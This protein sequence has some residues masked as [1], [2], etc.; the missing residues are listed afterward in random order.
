[1]WM[2]IVAV[3]T[4]ACAVAANQILSDGSWQWWPWA[5]I[6]VSTALVGVVIANRPTS[7]ARIDSLDLSDCVKEE[8]QTDDA[9]ALP[10][11]GLAYCGTASSIWPLRFGA[12]PPQAECFQDRDLA[13]LLTDRLAQGDTVALARNTPSAQVL[14]GLGGVGKTQLAA[15]HAHRLWANQQLDLLVWITAGS[16]RDIQVA[17]AKL[18]ERVLD[19]K[20]NGHDMPDPGE[21]ARRLLEWL[22]TTPLRWLIVL[23]DLVEPNDLHGLWPPHSPTGQV[24]VTTRRRDA[25]MRGGHRDI[26]DVGL[27]TDSEALA[28]LVARL[29]NRA[30]TT[31]EQDEMARLANDLEWLPLALAQAAA[32]LIN[33]P[34]LTCA[35]YRQRLGDRRTILDGVLPA[36]RELPDE[37]HHTVAA[38]WSLSI[39]RA[40]QLDPVGLARPILELMS[41]LDP[42]G[43]PADLFAT[44]AV[45]S[46]LSDLLGQSI[47]SKQAEDAIGCLYRLSLLSLDTDQCAR[48]IRV[49]AL[50]QR[51]TRESLSTAELAMIASV[52]GEAILTAWPGE[53]YELRTSLRSN[54]SALFCHA[55]T[56]LWT[57]NARRLLL[58]VADDLTDQ[59]LHADTFP[60]L[61]DEAMLH[62]GVDD[63]DTLTIR[64]RLASYYAEA[65]EFDRA[66]SQA[67][68][69]L[70]GHLQLFGADHVD[71]LATS[72]SIA[73]WHMKM[74]RPDKALIELEGLVS[75]QTR[76]AGPDNQLTL[77]TR[78][79]LA[80]ARSES[81][82]PTRAM[83]ELKQ[84]VADQI[85]LFGPGHELSL[86]ARAHLIRVLARAG[87]YI[88]ATAEFEQLI[89]DRM[90]ILGP[91]GRIIPT[92][93][94]SLV[95]H[96]K[97]E[98][99]S[100]RW[101]V[102]C[103]KLMLDVAGIPYGS[104]YELLLGRYEFIHESAAYNTAWAIK[105][106][107]ALLVDALH[108]WG[109]ASPLTLAMRHNLAK[110]L[111]WSGDTVGAIAEW[112]LL[113]IDQLRILGPDHPDTR[114]T[115]ENLIRL[116]GKRIGWRQSHLW[117]RRQ[118]RRLAL[119]QKR[120]RPSGWPSRTPIDEALQNI[121][122]TMP[123]NDS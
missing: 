78:V 92:L 121:R 58:A 116:S 97:F 27:F 106:L 73:R 89:A 83:A 117:L 20:P 3:L 115:Q 17:Y 7:M 51:V 60:E 122:A 4:V 69:L 104:S 46:Y 54:V 72:H 105:N 5:P 10:N 49:H 85:Q 22:A 33:R 62:A 74:G 87:Q 70:A 18:A 91:S 94:S 65:G 9:I 81:G 90:Q 25:A 61:L 26:L 120:K 41:V 108:A 88:I 80:I 28:Y 113:T 110:W 31:Q 86:N 8:P 35:E 37:Q 42:V 43:I 84:L 75:T 93:E 77:Q 107:T 109:S 19:S 114:A 24:L 12:V 112:E 119:G 21:A 44:S 56:H 59:Y 67:E 48:A 32:Y 47:G 103:K 45:S 29:P 14:A 71:T 36:Q 53:E 52:V 82:D 15:N 101:T 102:T 34:L 118:N 30:N 98:G 96:R 11:W 79:E 6:A 50:V 13:R 23:D 38:T 40:N 99:E 68:H 1:M 64:E 16:Q 100:Q 66:V 123:P 63:P 95:S 76:V 55:R 2:P 39:E 111:E 57:S